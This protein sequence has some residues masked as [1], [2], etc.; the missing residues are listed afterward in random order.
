MNAQ[1][2]AHYRTVAGVLA[3]A[4]AAVA[5]P[6]GAQPAERTTGTVLRDGV[7]ETYV[8]KRGDTL[9]DI[10]AMF[11]RDPWLWPDI[12]QVN[13][14]IANPHLIYPGDIIRLIWVDG[15][16]QLVVDRTR[17][18]RLSPGM[19]V[20]ELD[21]PIPMIPL[22]AIRPFL[23]RPSVIGRDELDEAPYL[24]RAVDGRLMSAQ[25]TR[26]YARGFGED[27]ALEWTVVRKGQ[28]YRDPE[29]RE[30]LGYEAMYIADATLDRLGDPATILIT[31][32]RQEAMTGDRLI[33]GAAP[34]SD[35][36][37][38]RAP[39][40]DV[41]GRIIAIVGEGLT[42]SQ[43][44]VVVINRGMRDGVE[45]GVVLSLWRAGEKMKDPNAR[46]GWFRSRTVQLPDERGGELIVFR[47][48]ERVA[49]GLVMRSTRDMAIGDLVK[50]P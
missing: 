6:L 14:E 46:G 10:S 49:Y 1:R 12:W 22:E 48:T 21:D 35:N 33:H 7:P 13:P 43:Y 16:P 47:A 17:T 40:M 39:E 45:P 23:D 42:V 32:S 28:E 25:G 18:E 11:L 2:T 30:V 41:T 3:C 20:S 27:P 8:V 36:L 5:A 44:K 37:Y 29:T 34:L 15:R 26:V 9:W 31:A 38:P 4:L 19:R 24:L 50:N